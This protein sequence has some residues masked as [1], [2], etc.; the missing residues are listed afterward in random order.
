MGMAESET[1]PIADAAPLC[2]LSAAALREA[3]QD[4]RLS[5]LEVAT[6][7]LDRAEA[8]Q[9]RFNA[10]TR[11]DRATALAA[12]AASEGRWWRGVP[13]SPI[14][15]VPTT[16]KDIVWVK[17]WP[18]RYGSPST[19]DTPCAADAPAVA[20]LKAAGVTILGLT[21][22]PE[23]GW[24]AL[25]DGPLSG[26]TTNPWNP[27]MTP[28]GSSGGAA[29]AAVTGAG[30]LHLGTD[31]GGSIRVPSAFTGIV[32]LKPSYGRVPAFPDSAFGTVAHLGPMGRRVDDV[33]AM[34]AGMS[35]TDPQDWLQGPAPLP[36]LDA[37]TPLLAGARVGVWSTP[38]CGTVDPE[39]AAAFAG[40]VAGLEAAGAAVA[41]IV[42][43]AADVLDIF[44][45]LWFSGAATR[46]ASLTPAQRAAL[47]PGFAE[48][49]AVGETYTA[50]RYVQ[51]MAA[52]AAFGQAMDALLAQ[53]DMIVSPA[54]AI[55][56]FE[57]GHE[58]PPGSGLS[59][60][61]EWAGFSFP[62][63][64]TQQPAA[65]VPCGRTAAGLPIGL[66]II[67]A[68]GEDARVL[69]YARAIETRFP[70]FFL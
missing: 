27:A 23:F 26:V 46:A 5:P 34:L 43:P 8:V 15:G 47:D 68:R 65:A 40:I 18:I 63:N 7:A 51:A 11:I 10:F 21:T 33:A 14:D 45:V 49:V 70:A 54:T 42:L 38:P 36:P 6:A 57:A 56:A 30:V 58:V 50:V 25:T 19:P 35:G 64:L 53:F 55:P 62:I 41:P 28:G 32:G 13:L 12:A 29:V 52:R 60:W 31:G 48:I 24:K 17:D 67:G 39:V 22:T 2:R 69:G 59:R 1:T 37:P 20:R 3:F 44:N 66:Q 4:R 9:A 61:I 16:I